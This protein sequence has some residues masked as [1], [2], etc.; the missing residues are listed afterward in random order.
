MRDQAQ[1]TQAVRLSCLRAI[2][3]QMDPRLALK[4]CNFRWARHPNARPSSASLG[5]ALDQVVPRNLS[6]FDAV[7]P[8]QANLMP[9]IGHGARRRL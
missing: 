6:R 9:Q 1:G 2:C 4:T 7:G 3:I 5:M 8:S